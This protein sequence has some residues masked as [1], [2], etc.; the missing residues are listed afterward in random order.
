LK[1]TIIQNN[2]LGWRGILP[3]QFILLIWSANIFPSIFPKFLGKD[4]NPSPLKISSVVRL[5]LILT[6]CIGIISSLFDFFHLRFY[7][8]MNDN[9]TWFTSQGGIS[10]DFSIG[11]RNLSLRH[12]YDF[13]KAKYPQDTIIQ[14]NP[15]VLD[16]DFAQGL[17]GDH[18]TVVSGPGATTYGVS[19]QKYQELFAKIQ[20]IFE[21]ASLSWE[22]VNRICR[23]H[24]AKILI[25]TDIDPVWRNPG[26]WIWQ[27]QPIFE[28]SYVRLFKC[29]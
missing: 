6:L 25:V 15:D 28:T 16:I 22:A 10:S 13:I 24:G 17:Y 20:P 5:S 4:D 21:K 1:S 23:E 14:N 12:A 26:S 7:Y 19:F 8:L 29:R 11:K 18:Q 2:D 3:A 27:N 9:Q